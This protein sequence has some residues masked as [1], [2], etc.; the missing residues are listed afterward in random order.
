MQRATELFLFEERQADSPLAER[1]WRTRSVPEAAFIS[2]AVP[3]WEMVVTRQDGRASVTVRGPETVAS[4]VPIPQDAD[5]FGVPFTLGVF[6]P[7]LAPGQLVDGQLSLPQASADAFWLNGAVWDLPDY[8]NVE[9]FLR[10]LVREG[11]L[12][13]DPVV[14][15]SLQGSQIDVSPRTIQ[16][17]L[18][19][20]TGLTLQT[21]RQIDRAQRA[22]TLMGE[23]RSIHDTVHLVDYADQAHLTR[24]LKR[25]LGQ[26]PT[27]MKPNVR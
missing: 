11:L 5:F 16:R 7:D 14:V 17:R 12:V 24:S 8:E 20:A 15:A 1:I 6:M 27:E 18:L 4:I 13:R 2:V 25:F 21:I 9:F 3:Y 23:G 10:R 19:R 26:T 22:A